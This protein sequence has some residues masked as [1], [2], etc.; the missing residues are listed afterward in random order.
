MA[1]AAPNADPPVPESEDG[2]LSEGDEEEEPQ[3]P[4]ARYE[5]PPGFSPAASGARPG[6]TPQGST[7]RGGHVDSEFAMFE[8]FV[9]RREA[10]RPRGRRQAPGDEDEDDHGGRG[11]AGPPPA[12][13]GETSFKDYLVR[14]K[15][16]IATTK[17]KP[18]ARGP[19]LLKNLTGTPFDDLKHLAKDSTWMSSEDNAEQLLKI[20][21]TKELY[22]D[23]A[24]EDMLNTLY[25]V[26]YALR[27]EKNE[28]HKAFFSRWENCVRRL[29]EHEVT[30]PPEYLG[31]L[32]TMALQLSS[33]E[34][35]LLMNFTQGRLSQKDVKEWVRVHETNL[36]LGSSGNAKRSTQVMHVEEHSDIE[37]GEDGDNI[38]ILMGA[39]DSLEEPIPENDM[40]E[41]D[42]FDESDA[43]DILSTMIK[44]YAKG[45]TKRTFKAVNDA[46][47][48]K[49]L[50]RGYGSTRDIGNKFQNGKGGDYVKTGE[51][52]K[53]S[54]EALKRRTRCSH[55]RRVGHWHKECP[56]KN[57]PKVK[58]ANYLT[59]DNEEAYFLHFLDFRR[60]SRRNSGSGAGD[61]FFEGA[62][63][64]TTRT[65]EPSRGNS[66]KDREDRYKPQ[67]V[68]MCTCQKFMSMKFRARILTTAR[69][70][71]IH[72]I[73][74]TMEGQNKQARRPEWSHAETSWRR[75][76][77]HLLAPGG[78][79][80]RRAKDHAAV[81]GDEGPQEHPPA[82]DDGAG[83]GSEHEDLTDEEH[84]EV[85]SEMAPEQMAHQD[86]RKRTSTATGS[87]EAVTDSPMPMHPNP[88]EIETHTEPGEE[89]SQSEEPKLGEHAADDYN[90]EPDAILERTGRMPTSECHQCGARC[91][92]CGHVLRR[93]S[94][95]FQKEY[96][97]QRGVELRPPRDL[98]DKQ[99]EAKPKPRS[100]ARSSGREP[101]QEDYEEYQEFLR[102]RAMRDQSS[103]SNL[104]N[105]G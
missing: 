32:L 81:P 56:D 18:K 72:L 90:K 19:M 2:D 45:T 79:R 26:T 36:K 59:Y 17:T 8:E 39:L 95:T 44:E 61:E 7:G 15:L 21:D 84:W 10:A 87:N 104:P 28:T 78:H 70:L 80:Q 103:S 38:E 98:P 93:E 12:W 27:R 37:D 63:D 47:R 11:S 49:G 82:A 55:C 60:A 14:A 77:L 52:H 76:T 73:H 75:L 30:L 86:N 71:P 99:A 92:D 31:F 89:V 53:V 94:T 65:S 85:L 100:T 5:R 64:L 51:S 22:G 74:S 69:V 48:A 1:A 20:M 96:Y 54:I 41:G 34:V 101:P 83:G 6:N 9:R 62:V 105:K 58:E 23:D 13:D 91:V 88:E 33:E 42:V 68:R 102:F 46:K 57:K 66:S 4:W 24:R 40:H 50:A 67:A 97:R 35:K 43:K 25:K 3:D 16:W 29:S